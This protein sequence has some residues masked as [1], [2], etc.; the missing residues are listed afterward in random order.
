MKRV[1]IIFANI[2]RKQKNLLFFQEEEEEE[3]YTKY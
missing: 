2:K 3:M 1:Y